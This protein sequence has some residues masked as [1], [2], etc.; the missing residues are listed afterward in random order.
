MSTCYDITIG[1]VKADPYR[2]MLAYGIT[3]PA[4]QHALKKLLRAGQSH[5]PIEQDIAETIASLHRW[6]EM[7]EEDKAA[8]ARAEAEIAHDLSL[9]S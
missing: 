4:Q 9:A 8:L 3:H 6:L 1:G 5:K 7:I 2:I